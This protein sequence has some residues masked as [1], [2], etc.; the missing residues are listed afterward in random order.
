MT[1]RNLWVTAVVLAIGGAPGPALAGDG[2]AGDG[3]KLRVVN[4][5]VTL[6]PIREDETATAVFILENVGGADLI[7]DA[8]RASCGCTTVDLTEKEK[9]IPPG[10]KRELKVKFN[11][12]GR[13]GPNSKTVKVTVNDEERPVVELRLNV[14]VLTLFQ[15]MPS[16]H[17]RVRNVRPGEP[18]ART[19]DI[20]PSRPG[21]V[22]ELVSLK[23]DPSALTYATEP[24]VR[25]EF[26]GQRLR[27][28]VREDASLGRI[29]T[30]AKMTVRVGKA[31]QTKQVMITGQVIGDFQVVPG[32]VQGKLS[33][34]FVRGLELRPVR[35]SSY[36]ERPFEILGA[37]AGPN[38]DVAV[39]PRQDRTEWTVK[40]RISEDAVDGPCGAFLEVRTDSPLEPLI[41]VP[42][43]VNVRPRLEPDPPVVLLRA[44]GQSSQLTR[45]VVLRTADLG[46]FAIQGLDCDRGFVHVEPVRP[47][48]E[49][50]GERMIAVTVDPDGLQQGT[51]QAVVTVRTD[52]PRAEEVRV[53]VTVL[54]SGPT[55]QAARR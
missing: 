19:L 15:L 40:V 48:R 12:K 7:I 51:H 11:G 16:A 41:R 49:R 10:T 46:E 14:E 6:D 26:R 33:E 47:D 35:I 18:V 45:R 50:V 21:E 34:P 3:P 27:L 22:A 42:V 31:T 55:G 25:G 53:P 38:F 20:L 37:S 8:V 13:P 52:A 36:A 44:G 23:M 17:L 29:K 54:V 43:Y 9:T 28:L 30:R 5:T 39:E 1:S 32:T 24:L 4:P 2:A